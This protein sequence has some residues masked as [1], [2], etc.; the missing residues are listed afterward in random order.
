[1]IPRL[2]EMYCSEIRPAMA[3]ELGYA[4]IHTI[5]GLK[6][7]VV[8]MGLGRKEKK[9]FESAVDEMAAI[10]GQKPLVIVAK[11]SIAGFK[12]REGMDLGIKVTLRK[13][14]MYEFLDRLV[15][16]A[17][18]R[19]RDFRGISG[20]SFDGNGN[21]SLGIKEHHIF[22]EVNYDR[23]DHILGMDISIV[24]SAR[25]D[26]EGK[27]LLQKFGIPFRN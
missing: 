1:M 9:V 7:I 24:T 20:S 11:K 10:T 23:V 22:P 13:N 5:P 21:L 2:K 8:N 4:N 17:M 26:E 14:R 3:K 27:V 19:I 16:I 25:T 6:K 18:P 15:T 12:L